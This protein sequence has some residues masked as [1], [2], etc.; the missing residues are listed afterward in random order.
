MIHFRVTQKVLF[1]HCDPAGIMFFPRACEIVN[2]TVEALFDGPLGWRFD[3]MHPDAG[4]PTAELNMTFKRPCRHGEVLRLEQEI[5]RI[6]SSALDLET[7]AMCE[8]ELRFAATQTLVCV[9]REGRP[10]QWP[11][12]VRDRLE[13]MMKGAI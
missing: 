4:V 3:Q 9:G 7:R 11:A 2:D 8:D 5:K 1:R 13:E 12:G 6:G 10:M